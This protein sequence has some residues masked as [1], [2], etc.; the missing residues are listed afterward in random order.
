MPRMFNCSFCG[1]KCVADDEKRALEHQDP[2]C[3]MYTKVCEVLGG[4]REPDV[5]RNA[6]TGEIIKPIG[7]T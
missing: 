7:S 6:D 3:A 1:L 5:L 2:P 4:K